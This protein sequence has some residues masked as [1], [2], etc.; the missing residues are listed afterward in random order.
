[1]ASS[2]QNLR[3]DDDDAPLIYKRRRLSEPGFQSQRPVQR[4]RSWIVEE[5]EDDEELV[6]VE[7]IINLES[8]QDD[9]DHELELIPNIVRSRMTNVSSLLNNVNE[10]S[11]RIMLTDPE[12]LECP[13][14][15]DQLFTPVLQV[16]YMLG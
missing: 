8:E 4:F 6:R 9:N 3:E 16:L 12:A 13:I 14:C 11:L 7:D 5:D 10:A 2:A 15:L 1:M